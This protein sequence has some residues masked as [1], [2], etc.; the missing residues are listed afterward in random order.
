MASTISTVETHKKRDKI[1]QAIIDGVANREI[2]RKYKVNEAAIRRYIRG[3]FAEGLVSAVRQ[4][5]ITSGD[6]KFYYLSRNFERL[7]KMVLGLEEMLFHPDG[8][9]SYNMDPRSWD[10][11][12]MY[13]RMVNGAVTSQVESLDVLL[14][15]VDTKYTVKTWKYRGRDIRVLMLN[16][17]KDQM[18]SL[19][20]LLE[21]EKN[22]KDIQTEEAVRN[23]WN[24]LQAK[25]VEVTDGKP[26]LRRQIGGF[27]RLVGKSIAK[28]H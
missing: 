28:D 15:L 9:G 8:S 13:E 20:V 6:F 7:E 14:S 11:D 22:A 5:E 27:F 3:K 1:D 10:V 12:V 18:G 17:L 19:R 25:F 26:D 21:A 16:A 24:V 2:A 4:R 23:L